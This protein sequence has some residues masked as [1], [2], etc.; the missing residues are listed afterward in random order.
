M[1]RRNIYRDSDVLLPIHFEL[2]RT[3]AHQQLP[4]VGLVRTTGEET[5]DDV[6]HDGD[7]QW[8]PLVKD[9]DLCDDEKGQFYISI[10]EVVA[11]C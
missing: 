3:A 11:H 10:H 1:R 9:D 2:L 6:Y 8:L 4:P 5:S 7:R